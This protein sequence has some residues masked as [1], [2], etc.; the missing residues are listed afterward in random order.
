MSDLTFGL[1]AYD[2]TV[3]GTLLALIIRDWFVE[4]RKKALPTSSVVFYDKSF[5]AA[6]ARDMKMSPSTW[7]KVMNPLC[8][9]CIRAGQTRGQFK[10]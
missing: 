10:P 3:G 9:I 4:R 6:L 1:L 5:V 7:H 2:I 8:G